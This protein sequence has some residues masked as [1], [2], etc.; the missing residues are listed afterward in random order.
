MPDKGGVKLEEDIANKK[1]VCV[2]EK[3]RFPTVI[4]GYLRLTHRWLVVSW[5]MSAQPTVQFVA[6]PSID[7]AEPADALF[8]LPSGYTD[9]RE[10]MP[11][12]QPDSRQ[13]GARLYRLQVRQRP[14][15]ARDES[16][17]N[18][19]APYRLEFECV[20]DTGGVVHLNL[21]GGPDT[22]VWRDIQPDCEIQVAGR[23][24]RGFNGRIQLFDAERIGR[25]GYVRADYTGI[26]GKCAG[27]EI[28]ACIASVPV[29]MDI[30]SHAAERLSAAIGIRQERLAGLIARD[31]RVTT[32]MVFF[33]M[34]H[35]P[36]DPVAGYRAIGIARRLCVA[37]IRRR[38]SISNRSRTAIEP[39]ILSSSQVREVM[40][41]VP[42]ELTPAQNDAVMQIVDCLRG[43]FPARIL[44]S[45]DVGSGKTLCFAV[46]AAIAAR[47]GRKV[48]ILAPTQILARQLHRQLSLRWPDCAAELILSGSVLNQDARIAVGTTALIGAAAKI[49]WLPD[50]LIVD[51]QHKYS[52][53]QRRALAGQSTHIIE[54]SATPIPRSLAMSVFAG[55]RNLSLASR[56]VDRQID[57]MLIEESA[58]SDV[59]RMLPD[60]L[61]LGGKAVLLYPAV[62]TGDKSV[63][64]AADRLCARLG[65]KMGVVHGKMPDK[66]RDAILARFRDGAAPLLVAS[67]IIEV[68]IDIP[69]IALMVVN[70]ADR[71][72]AAQLHQLRGRLA[73]DGGPGRFILLVDSLARLDKTARARLEAVRDISNGFD[74]AERDLEIRGFGEVAG[75]A[76]SGAADPLFKLCRL[77]P[78]DFLRERDR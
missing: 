74:L 25:G 12:C 20:D 77:V 49:N 38:A 14:G 23:P 71:F 65:D 11:V 21:F 44:L 22:L 6:C 28:A 60:C 8:L 55:M 37:E 56:P 34:I 27:S 54:A 24:V 41:S 30:Y 53:D 10:A 64:A 29:C 15:A 26:P 59:S 18:S 46:P 43:P 3:P 76:Q 73:R 35:A 61:R 68:G 39:W 66:E 7:A 52:V 36:P 40:E 47:S 45:G 50:L 31:L 48:A 32:V 4:Q 2:T 69:G 63:M 67:T 17:D 16:P 75:E 9:L 13:P 70:Q 57:S 42:E 1:P 33:R 58:R 78:R 72:G 5:C 51:E 62:K 19:L